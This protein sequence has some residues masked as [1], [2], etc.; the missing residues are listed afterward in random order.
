[1]KENSRM[2]VLVAGLGGGWHPINY[3]EPEE[4]KGEKGKPKAPKMR[5]TRAKTWPGPAF[6]LSCK[7]APNQ[8]NWTADQCWS[9]CCQGLKA[10]A[11]T[12]ASPCTHAR[13]EKLLPEWARACR[14][15]R[16]FAKEDTKRHL[17]LKTGWPRE[18][19]GAW[20]NGSGQNRRL[21]P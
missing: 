20:A 16:T 6:P 21:W 12:W 8:E 13:A 15:Q 11:R 5:L 14:G 4:E 9:S 19:W 1:M 7:H 17:H 18:H 2:M 3:K 10:M